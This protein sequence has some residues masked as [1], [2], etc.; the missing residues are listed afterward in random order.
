MRKALKIGAV[1]CCIIGL[2]TGA[3]S[4]SS[5][6]KPWPN[7]FR[8]P[9]IYIASLYAFLAFIPMIVIFLSKSIEK[10]RFRFVL[11]GIIEII[12]IFL[13]LMAVTFPPKI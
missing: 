11:I 2:Y 4:I 7:E 6:V 9:D 13:F 1:I 8:D 10:P 5:I 3:I 12:V